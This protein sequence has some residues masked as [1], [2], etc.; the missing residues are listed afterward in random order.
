MSAESPNFRYDVAE[1][2][3]KLP[4]VEVVGKAGLV[5]RR[6]GGLS[7]VA[8][9]FHQERSASMV[10]YESHAHCF[11]CSWHGDGLAFWMEIK[12][13]DFKR[14]VEDLAGMAGVRAVT[15]AEAA[16]WRS[17]ISR[18]AAVSRER[19]RPVVPDLRRLT[20]EEV[21]SLA[22]QRGLSAEGVGDAGAR[23]LLYWCCHQ[24]QA[25]WCLTDRSR[26]NVQVR[27]LDGRKWFDEVKA[28]T[29]AGSWAAWPVG[30]TE[31]GAARRIALV[32]GGPDALAMCDL[33]VRWGWG[34]ADC[35]LA[36]MFGAS[37]A[38][39]PWCLQRFQSA[40]VRIFAHNDPEKNGRR[41]GAEGAE[42]W[43]KQ[44]GTVAR[45]VDWVSAPDG[46]VLPNGGRVCDVND[47]L[48]WEGADTERAGVV[49]EGWRF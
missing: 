19:E 46:L 25:A 33:M 13:I 34:A 49:T 47:V 14:A 2:K 35:G 24:G 41:A 31:F 16:T 10:V 7:K 20:M 36:I 22:A 37:A 29:L 1:I 48:V 23:G 26:R 5:L 12:G 32:E 18:P 44:L 30:C 27:R 9:P 6:M 38:I 39:A 43:A 8:C 45:E 11:G 17:N 28:W 21:A 40:R 4:M 42:R 3:A 15:A